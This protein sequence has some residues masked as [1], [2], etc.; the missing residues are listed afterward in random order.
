MGSHCNLQIPMSVQLGPILVIRRASIPWGVTPAAA[1][2]DTLSTVTG[3]RVMVRG[4]V[5]GVGRGL[6]GGETN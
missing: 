5:M 6:G 2:L 4:C 1:T 3:L